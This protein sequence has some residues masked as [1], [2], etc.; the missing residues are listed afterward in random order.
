[1]KKL[2][3]III[4]VSAIACKNSEPIDYAIISGTVLNTA[5]PKTLSINAMDRSFTKTLEITEA[6]AFVDTLKTNIKDYVLYDGKNPVFLYVTPGDNIAINYDVK[7]FD[8]T[9]QITGEGSR[10]SNYMVKKRAIEKEQLDGKNN[11]YQLQ[12]TEFK[13]LANKIADL[14]IEEL[15]KTAGIPEDY[16]AKERKS[17]NYLYLNLLK[18]YENQYKRVNRTQNF[19][20][21]DGFLTELETIDYDIDEDYEFS[22][23]YKQLVN[24]YFFEKTKAL[25]TTKGLTNGMALIESLN[26]IA[27]KDSRIRNEMLYNYANQNLTREKDIKGFYNAF[28]ANSTNEEQKT[29]ITET[30][31]KLNATN[32]GEPSPKFVNYENNAGGTTSLD[33]LKGKYV[34][35]DVWATWCGPCIKEIPALK[36]VEKQFHGKN[37]EF[38]SISID[39]EKDHDKWKKMIVDKDLKGMQ[40]MADNEW[41]SSFVEDY[42]I[43]GIPRFILIDPAGNIVNA[44]APRPSSP[45]LVSLIESLKI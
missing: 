40:L 11:P 25:S 42:A 21:T 33:D 6:G 34:Y 3:I 5:G 22:I 23:Y 24:N 28:I 18:N 8:N 27:S 39:K 13:E 35:I 31:K 43:K 9:L 37:I 4:A 17:I 32:P 20:V 44:N 14:Q 10:I 38:V 7:D 45:S 16:V 30:Y 26:E 41:K 1:M 19:K 36:E 29:K 12:E 2:L 15:E